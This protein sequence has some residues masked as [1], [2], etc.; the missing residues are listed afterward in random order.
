[1]YEIEEIVY[2]GYGSHQRKGGGY[3]C[4][5]VTTHAKL[6]EALASG[7]YRTLDEAIAAHDDAPKV[8]AVKAVPVPEAPKAEPV[9]DA[10]KP[11]APEIPT[12]IKR[13]GR[14]PKE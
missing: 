1:M 4:L 6:E 8:E 14:P 2:R 3:T 11:K 13:R 5:G 10:P 7:W 9:K 12:L